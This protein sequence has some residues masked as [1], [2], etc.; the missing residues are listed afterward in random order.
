MN[1]KKVLKNTNAVASNTNKKK[2]ILFMSVSK[3]VLFRTNSIQ[4][5]GEASQNYKGVD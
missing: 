4:R 5:Y 2:S 3:H 1:A